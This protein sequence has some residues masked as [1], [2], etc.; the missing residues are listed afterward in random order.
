MAIAITPTQLRAGCVVL[1][2]CVY[3]V[4]AGIQRGA[5]DSAKGALILLF[6][7]PQSVCA[8]HLA[9]QTGRRPALW[10]CLTFLTV[11]IGPVVLA[12]LS[13][14]VN[15]GDPEPPVLVP[16][17]P[18]RDQCSRCRRAVHEPSAAQ[19]DEYIRREQ[20]EQLQAI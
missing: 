10:A 12:F 3:G 6:M 11:S 16:P 15:T 5:D 14:V 8:Y 1:G 13:P 9:A 4:A 2:L 20:M 17:L 19:V 18:D 7:V